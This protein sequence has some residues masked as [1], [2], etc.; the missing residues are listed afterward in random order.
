MFGDMQC[1]T[2]SYIWKLIFIRLYNYSF[3]I[4]TPLG[5]YILHACAELLCVLAFPKMVYN[6][7]SLSDAMC[8]SMCWV[9]HTEKVHGWNICRR[10]EQDFRQERSISRWSDAG[11]KGQLAQNKSASFSKPILADIHG[12]RTLSISS[13]L[14]MHVLNV[15]YH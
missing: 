3:S 15:K 5:Q 8:V 7:H 4:G 12:R 13:S 11:S 10:S 2:Y 6:I 1:H 9:R 14:S